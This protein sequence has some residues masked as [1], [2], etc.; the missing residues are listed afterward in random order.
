MGRNLPDYTQ[1]LYKIMVKPLD[2]QP[3]SDAPR[4]G[5][6]A[7]FK[8]PFTRYAIDFAVAVEDLRL[9]L[10]SDGFRHGNIEVMLAAYDIEGKPMNLVVNRSEIRMPAKD[11]ASV[12]RQG[13]QIH[14]EIDVPKSNT[15]LR[16]GI[17]DLKSANA[18]TLGIPLTASAK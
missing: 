18:G 2:P 3:P 4:A 15:F 10:T 8:G 6:N 14:K 16:T 5:T 7:D 1:I 11:Y 17:Y 13:L 12:Q 9:D